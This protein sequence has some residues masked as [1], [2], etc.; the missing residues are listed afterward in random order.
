MKN[1]LMA[2]VVGGGLFFLTGCETSL[3]KPD[4]KQ[5]IDV[6]KILD[7]VNEA[8]QTSIE[9]TNKDFPSLTSV[10]LDLQ[11]A[12]TNSADASLKFPVVLTAGAKISHEK[13]HQITLT[14]TPAEEKRK[15]AAAPHETRLASAIRAVYQSVAHSNKAFQLH[16]G[17]IKLQCTLKSELDGGVTILGLVPIQGDASSVNSTVQTLTLNFGNPVAT[18]VFTIPQEASNPTPATP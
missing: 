12:V 4:P 17:S 2:C 13:L 9:P 8:I 10:T 16:N 11:V 14:F 18:R 5:T 3:P 15:P 6:V 1:I 7:Q